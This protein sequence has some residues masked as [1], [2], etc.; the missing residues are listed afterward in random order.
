MPHCPSYQVN[1]LNTS[2]LKSSLSFFLIE[3]KETWSMSIFM[4]W[5]TDHYICT[6]GKLLDVMLFFIKICFFMWFLYAPD[7]F[8][9][10]VLSGMF[11]AWYRTQCFFCVNHLIWVC[12]YQLVESQEVFYM[13]SAGCFFCLLFF[14]F[15]SQR[16]SNDQTKYLTPFLHIQLIGVER[17]KLIWGRFNFSFKKERNV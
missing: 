7:S 1:S 15:W 8:L 16:N 12:C 17:S 14:L 2:H 13:G 6:G 4:S 10:V 5:I 9:N 3:S 11:L